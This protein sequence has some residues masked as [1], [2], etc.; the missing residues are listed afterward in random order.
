MSLLASG[1]ALGRDLLSSGGGPNIAKRLS[2]EVGRTVLQRDAPFV[3]ANRALGAETVALPGG[4]PTP[5][6]LG[7]PP[8]GTVE[9]TFGFAAPI[10]RTVGTGIARA[11]GA[12][13]RMLGGGGGLVRTSTG[14][15]SSIILP[16]GQRFSR[17][18]AAAVVRRFGF[19][20]AATVLGIG[21]IEAAELLLTDAQTAARR[22]R[23]GVTFN[24]VQNAKRTV[25]MINKLQKDL[26][27]KPTVRRARTC[28]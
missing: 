16:S 9:A 10:A 2:R 24:Q 4:A 8:P 15:I 12:V 17:K 6:I 22:R 13:G 3:R 27:C 23:R 21:V 20:V 11:G 5:P 1:L 28:R 25:C 14:R 26:N 7:G 18:R 19:D